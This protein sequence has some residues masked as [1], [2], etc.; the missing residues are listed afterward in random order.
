MQ[1]SP[2]V[3]GAPRARV[4]WFAIAAYTAAASG[5]GAREGLVSADSSGAGGAGSSD[6][7][8][9]SSATRGAGSTGAAGGGAVGGG[10]GTGG[11]PVKCAAM[12][13][14]D[15]VFVLPDELGLAAQPDVALAP[16]DS[17]AV[18]AWIDGVGSGSLH[19]AELA[20]FGA[21]PPTLAVQSPG[22]AVGS[23]VLGEGLFGPVA[24]V[25]DLATGVPALM[26]ELSSEPEPMYVTS[27][28]P[29][30][31]A[32]RGDGGDGGDGER[33]LF[34]S[35]N[36]LPSYETLGVGSYQ[37]NSLPQAESPF[38]CLKSAVLAAGVLS[39]GGFLGAYAM[40]DPA[41]SDCP[42]GGE[43]G[44][45]IGI[46]RYDSPAEPGTFLQ[47]FAGDRLQPVPGDPLVH[48]GL[49]R[50]SFGAWL[51]YQ[52]AGLD[53]VVPPPP[54]GLRIDADGIAVVPG[55]L[56]APLG[57]SSISPWLAVASVGDALAVAYIEPLATGAPVITV[58]VLNESG[59]YLAPISIDTTA[60]PQTGRM[61]MVGTRDGQHLLLVW[62]GGLDT[63]TTAVARID[64]I[65]VDRP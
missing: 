59:A 21:W 37:P 24:W 42:V 49:A 62:Q 18:V 60:V 17:G 64:C 56:G 33:Y 36:E 25:H 22:T 44:T 55:D 41:L 28:A 47:V 11:G 9:S 54:M 14:A 10:G 13:L 7:P 46:Y 3:C 6:A 52:N 23:F 35:G 32:A 16:N 1:R 45:S 2:T 15:P 40:T 29:L 12:Q 57:P 20:A 19:A 30:F 5:C 50:T 65:S 63:P 34:A 26:R 51:V 31:V 48:L 8:A 39:P 27:G 53:T 61:R 58:Q 4:V 43:P 38:A